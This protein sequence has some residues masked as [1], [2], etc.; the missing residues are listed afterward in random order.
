MH[1]LMRPSARLHDSTKAIRDEI[2]ATNA[3]R[4]CIDGSTAAAF[5]ASQDQ[6]A[7]LVAMSDVSAR[8]ARARLCARRRD[9]CRRALP[10][11]VIVSKSCSRSWSSTT[12]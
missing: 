8:R 12:S 2:M 4:R 7:M 5:N 10:T 1:T 3:N 9:A 11:R 6:I